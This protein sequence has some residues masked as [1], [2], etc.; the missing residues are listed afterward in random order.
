MDSYDSI[1]MTIENES[2][3]AYVNNYLSKAVREYEENQRR[4]KKKVSERSI[5]KIEKRA[6]MELVKEYPELY[7]YY[8][9]YKEN[10]AD[11]N[12][13]ISKD[14][15]IIMRSINI[16]SHDG[17]FHGNI[18]VMLDDTTKLNALVKKLKDIKGVKQVNRI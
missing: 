17:I 9:K 15:K 13:I 5:A 7:D 1:R 14:E 6:F 8:I 10:N 18:T 12:N 4:N 3:R 16:D 2:L 11:L